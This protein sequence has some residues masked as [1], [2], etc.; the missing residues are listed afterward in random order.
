MKKVLTYV[1]SLA[2][3]MALTVAGTV[4]YLTDKDSETKNL[5]IK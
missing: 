1:L 5:L 3:V 2:L 4:A